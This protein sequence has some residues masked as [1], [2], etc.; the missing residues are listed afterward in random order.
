[1]DEGC[2]G[3]GK[4]SWNLV[5]LSKFSCSRGCYFTVL[6][7]ILPFCYSFGSCSVD[8]SRC[9]SK[10]QSELVVL[11]RSPWCQTAK[12]VGAVGYVCFGAPAAFPESYLSLS[13]RHRGGPAKEG[14]PDICKA[15]AQ[16]SPSCTESGVAVDFPCPFFPTAEGTGVLV[17]G[18]EF[19]LAA[20]R[21]ETIFCFIKLLLL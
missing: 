13:L 21:E 1:M 14:S 3:E 6:V 8:S 15:A 7:G 12:A 11:G 4:Q 17:P 9:L 19:L 5:H 18:R 20:L 2:Q 10:H 16:V